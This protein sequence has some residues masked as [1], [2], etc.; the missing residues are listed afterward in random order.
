[1]CV[2]MDSTINMPLYLC[3]APISLL[4]PQQHR[5]AMAARIGAAKVQGFRKGDLVDRSRED[6]PST[7]Y[8]GRGQ[9]CS[10][11]CDPRELAGIKVCLSLL[12]A[13][14]CF[15][16]EANA[17]EVHLALAVA[18]HPVLI[19]SAVCL[20]L[21]AHPTGAWPCMSIAVAAQPLPPL[22]FA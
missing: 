2:T 1:M 3:K 19:T 9:L 17:P 4:A 20:D 10:I 11:V 22:L 18:G 8:T 15:R 6:S 13:G 5:T 12:R 14:F 16:S 7:L 21:A